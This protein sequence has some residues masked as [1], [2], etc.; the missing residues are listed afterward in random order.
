VVTSF[1]RSV[2]VPGEEE[3]DEGSEEEGRCCEE[4]GDGAASY[5]ESLD[6][7]CGR[8][9]NMGGEWNKKRPMLRI[10]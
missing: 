10:R 8:L 6:Y 1:S 5:A 2:A 4:E 9:E 3:G 7:G